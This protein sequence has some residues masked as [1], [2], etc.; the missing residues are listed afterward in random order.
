MIEKNTE[1]I[2]IFDKFFKSNFI[3]LEVID[4]IDKNWRGKKYFKF[5]GV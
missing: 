5:G 2:L 3:T 4:F 1:F